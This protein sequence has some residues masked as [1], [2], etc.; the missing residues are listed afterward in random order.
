[1]PEHIVKLFSSSCSK[2]PCLLN[3]LHNFGSWIKNCKWIASGKSIRTIIDM[4][5]SKNSFYKCKYLRS[6]T[7]TNV[8]DLSQFYHVTILHKIKEY[9]HDTWLNRIR[10]KNRGFLVKLINIIAFTFPSLFQE[11]KNPYSSTLN[12]QLGSYSVVSLSSNHLSNTEP[13]LNNS[14]TSIRQLNSNFF[15]IFYGWSCQ[16]GNEVNLSFPRLRMK[17][18]PEQYNNLP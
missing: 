4:I 6:A 11:I 3:L 13:F 18:F 5:K 8:T 7:V 1:M 17:R 2:F 15:V 16:T 14:G 12:I 10:R 9:M